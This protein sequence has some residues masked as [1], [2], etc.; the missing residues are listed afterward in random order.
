MDPEPTH[1]LFIENIDW[2]VVIIILVLIGLLMLSA[3][4][5]A[6]EVAFFSLSKSVLHDLKNQ[7]RN[8]KI[9]VELLNNPAKLLTAIQIFNNFINTPVESDC[10]LLAN[11]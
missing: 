9:V 5:S 3:L 8:Q 2:P 6:G 4:I 11:G 10:T 1:L 7:N